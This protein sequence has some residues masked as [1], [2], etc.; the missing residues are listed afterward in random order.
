MAT[1]RGVRRTVPDLEPRLSL[2]NYFVTKN[3]ELPADTA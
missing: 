2:P 1:V 3:V